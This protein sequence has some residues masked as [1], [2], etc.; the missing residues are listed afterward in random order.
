M[1][2]VIKNTVPL[3]FTIEILQNCTNITVIAKNAFGILSHHS[4]NKIEA[5]KVHMNSVHVMMCL[6]LTSVE[7][8][9]LPTKTYSDTNA[10]CI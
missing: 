3:S 9:T 5:G 7:C 2:T 8:P 6:F 1:F 10:G 4:V